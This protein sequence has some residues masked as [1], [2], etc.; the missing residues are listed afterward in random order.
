MT[1]N[2]FGFVSVCRF[3]DNLAQKLSIQLEHQTTS[4]KEQ[5]PA[6]LGGV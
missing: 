1:S 3:K 6:V 5:T 4:T 2:K